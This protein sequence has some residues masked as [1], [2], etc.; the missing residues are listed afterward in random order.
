MLFYNKGGG[1]SFIYWFPRIYRAYTLL[2]IQTIK[3]SENCPFP[4][5]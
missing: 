3:I 2:G 4:T 1:D 5:V